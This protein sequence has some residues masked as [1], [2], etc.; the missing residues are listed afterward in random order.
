MP[1]ATV[2]PATD[3]RRRTLLGVCL[4]ACCGVFLIELVSF[5]MLKEGAGDHRGEG[6]RLLFQVLESRFALLSLGRNHVVI[7]AAG[8]IILHAGIAA[9]LSAALQHT[10]LRNR[11]LALSIAFLLFVAFE[12]ALVGLAVG[13]I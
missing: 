9:L 7:Y 4:G 1:P 12:G 10:W 6:M 8:G 11:R 13:K 3:P 5:L 2:I